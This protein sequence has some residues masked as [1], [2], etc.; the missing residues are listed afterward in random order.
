MG[1][2]EL[3]ARLQMGID[4]PPHPRIRAIALIDHEAE[5]LGMRRRETHVLANRGPGSIPWI[6]E[7]E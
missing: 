6:L 5:Y 2:H 7:L 4:Q 1:L 3:E